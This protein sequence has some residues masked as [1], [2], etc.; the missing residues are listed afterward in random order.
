MV[1]ALLV[2][3]LLSLQGACILFRFRKTPPLIGEIRQQANQT[4][5]ARTGA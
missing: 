2:F 4:L 1:L 3:F 5:H